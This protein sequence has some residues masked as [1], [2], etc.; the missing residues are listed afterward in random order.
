MREIEKKQLKLEAVK[1][2]AKNLEILMFQ[3]FHEFLNV[4]KAEKINKLLLYR[5]E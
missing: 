1:N 5:P 2:A 3:K 4:F